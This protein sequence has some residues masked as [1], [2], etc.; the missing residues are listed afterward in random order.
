MI[1]PDPNDDWAHLEQLPEASGD[2]IFRS[3]I[4]PNQLHNLN[5]LPYFNNL[6]FDNLL[7]DFGS[8]DDG[9]RPNV[10]SPRPNVESPRPNVES[11]R[12]NVESP[13]SNGDSPRRSLESSR[14]RRPRPTVPRSRGLRRETRISQGRK[15]SKDTIDDDLGGDEYAFREKLR[16]YQKDL[17]GVI[18]ANIKGGLSDVLEEC[19]PTGS[20]GSDDALSTFLQSVVSDRVNAINANA[21][22]S[23][24]TFVNHAYRVVQSIDGT[25][26]DSEQQASLLKS[27]RPDSQARQSP[28]VNLMSIKSAFVIQMFLSAKN[29]ISCTIKAIT[30]AAA[31]AQIEWSAADTFDDLHRM[32][33]TERQENAYL[34]QLVLAL[35]HSIHTW[36]YCVILNYSTSRH[37]G[38]IR[39]VVP[40]DA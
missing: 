26:V 33:R 4:Q 24:A 37:K 2:N 39:P 27:L 17:M 38:L 23:R 1:V 20:A 6:D 10:E 14:H 18:N 8:D 11:P 19:G 35:K 15:E 7:A 22:F 28:D 5:D 25:W 34:R 40:I 30:M 16:A 29:A 36:A 31:P 32:L 12:S 3:S 9:S 21:S 13:R